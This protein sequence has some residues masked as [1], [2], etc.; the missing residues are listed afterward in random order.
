MKKHK[1]LFTAKKFTK[2]F[3]IWIFIFNFKLITNESDAPTA[4]FRAEKLMNKKWILGFKIS[5]TK[6]GNSRTFAP[7]QEN[8]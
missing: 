3:I 5:I 7:E 6:R 8:V 1:R 2:L 4:G